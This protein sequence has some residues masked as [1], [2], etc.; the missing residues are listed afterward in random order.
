MPS[1][2]GQ[3]IV[4][5]KYKDPV[6]NEVGNRVGEGVRKLGIYSGGILTKVDDVTVSLS[7]LDCEIKSQSTTHQIRVQ[8]QSSVNITV[9][10]TDRFVVLR[11]D[12]TADEEQDYMSF[13]AVSTVLEK[14][15]VVGRCV[16]S[17]S[18]L[19]TFTYVERTEPNILDLY[20]KVEPLDSTMNIIVRGGTISYG[21]NSV[22]V[23]FQIFTVT[24]PISGTRI[25]LLQINSSGTL[26]QVTGT[27]VPASYSSNITVA[28]LTLNSGMSGIVASN[29]KDTRSFLSPALSI[30]SLINLIYPV[31]CIYTSTVSTN[32]G[33]LFGTG[34][35]Q[36]FGTGRCL[37]GV[38]ASDA[39]FNTPEKTGG[40]KTHTLTIAEMPNHNH[41]TP[42]NTNFGDSGQPAMESGKTYSPTN[43]PSTYV[44]GGLAHNN[45]QPYITVYFWKRTA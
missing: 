13:H 23:P 45:L 4:T 11:W 34:T 14:D 2:V 7:P 17:G 15:I 5:I 41:I 26:I 19:Q 37:V 20:L 24:K 40:A 25:D 36:A 1:N 8:T 16:F 27:S 33:T 42:L 43:Y 44:G 18:T 22:K 9:S 30:P 10:S 28:E 3:Q 39:D 35:W 38:N 21:D 32:P 29:I 6:D 31:G 12:Y